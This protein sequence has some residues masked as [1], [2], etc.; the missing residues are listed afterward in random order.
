MS[1][2]YRYGSNVPPRQRRPVAWYAPATLLHAGQELVY[3]EDFL[4]NYDRRETFAVNGHADLQVIDLA[5]RRA[6]DETPFVFDFIADTGDGGNATFAVA[7]GA[8]TADLSV[9]GAGG[10]RETLPEG[11]LLILGGDLAYPGASPAEYQYRFLEMFEMASQQPRRFTRVTHEGHEAGPLPHK[12]VAAIPQNHDWFD[13]AATFCRYFVN[14]DKG[15]FVGARTPQQQTY[16]AVRL[17]QDWWVLGFDWALSGDLDRFQFEA[18]AALAAGQF[19]AASDLIL[20]YPEPYWTRALGDGAPEGYPRRYQ[21]LESMLEKTGA[22]IRLRLAGDLHHYHRE[23]L[24]VDPHSGT[25]THLVTCGTGGAFLHP[26]HCVDVQGLKALDRDEEPQALDHELRHRVRC[27]RIETED[28]HPHTRFEPQCTY[29]EPT[30][31]RA[32]AC[33]GLPFSLFHVRLSQ[34]LGQLPWHRLP[35]ELWNSNLGFALA[36]GVL[37]GI[38]A[39][40]NSFVFS[41]SFHENGFD[42]MGT[43]PFARAASLWLTAMVFSPFATAVN[44]LMLGGCVRIAWEGPGPTLWR[45][46]SGLTHGIVHGFVIFTLYWVVTHGMQ[47]QLWGGHWGF[48][49]G[50]LAS[51]I[52]VGLGGMVA[53]ALLFGVYLAIAC[54]GFAQLPNNAFGALAIEDWKGFLRFRLSGDTLEVNMLGLDRVAADTTDAGAQQG[55]HIVDRFVLRKTSVAAPREQDF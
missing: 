10:T 46:V 49:L 38:N 7:R 40:V 18:F 27:G 33:W 34:P 39:Y 21:R 25:D 44:L 50:G 48:L 31:T 41:A 37:Y 53:G 11:E 4:R 20:V 43:L 36:L 5:D 35:G 13:S 12:F 55:W 28:A 1:V 22:R 3:S 42:P 2:S 14:H 24:Q 23:T 17:P 16:F 54:G 19:S 51:W 45:F 32:W 52:L 9:R 26:T 47:P 8:L 15:L 30:D 29:P 6:T